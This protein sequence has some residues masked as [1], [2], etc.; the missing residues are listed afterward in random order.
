MYM[1]KDMK[2]E[3]RQFLLSSLI[4]KTYGVECYKKESVLMVL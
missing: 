1:D 4:L 2:N 3:S